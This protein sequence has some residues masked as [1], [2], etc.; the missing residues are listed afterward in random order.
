[1]KHSIQPLLKAQLIQDPK[2]RELFLGDVLL[3]P[4]CHYTPTGANE[5]IINTVTQATE[6]SNVPV[7]LCTYANRTGK[8]FCA[9]NIIL[10]LIYETDNDWFKHKLFHEYFPHPKTIWYCSEP[11]PLK[12]EIVPKLEYLLTDKDEVEKNPKENQYT[13]EKG[14]KHYYSKYTFP[15]GWQLIFKSYQQAST[16][17]EG[18]TVGFIVCSEPMPEYLW[19]VI[20]G[21]RVHGCIIL[22]IMTQ[23]YTPPYVIDEVQKRANEGRKG[24][25][26]IEAD[27]YSACKKRGVRGFLDHDTVDEIVADMDPDER[28]ARAFGKPM[29]FSSMIFDDLDR[30]IHFVE[31]E[32]YPLSSSY[33]YFQSIDPHDAR[34]P[35]VTWGYLTP[36]GRICIFAEFPRDKSRNFWDM[37]TIYTLEAEKELYMQIESEFS[38]Y[39]SHNQV[40]RILD[41]H[42]AFQQRGKTKDGVKK[43]LY[44]QYNDIGLSFVPSYKSPTTDSEIIFGHKKIRKQLKYL[45][46]GK[47]GIVVWNTCFHTWNGLTHYIRRHEITK[48]AQE[49]AVNEGAI[50]QKYKDFPDCIRYLI[51]NDAGTEQEI[52]VPDMH[53]KHRDMFDYV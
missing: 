44:Q 16:T 40:T 30:E 26:H 46:D 13:R 1:M 17:Y 11:V 32:E 22:M 28:Q 35:A 5:L 21:R 12:D 49:K 18:G 4:L 7:I 50:V 25:C 14:D 51:C 10:N 19:K 2:D 36:A 31:P 23:L 8:D 3:H 42:F 34:P 45:E 38:D 48:L 52:F 24:Y 20:K 37:K 15:G 47:P 43:N 39:F 27:I 6:E 53:T 33:L 41:Y 29:Y 9:E